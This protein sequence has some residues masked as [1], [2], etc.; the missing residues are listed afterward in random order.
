MHEGIS[1]Y[2][3]VLVIYN[4]HELLTRKY[5]VFQLR[6]NKI[7]LSLNRELELKALMQRMTTIGTDMLTIKKEQH[8]LSDDVDAV[9]TECGTLEQK[10][11]KQ[12]LDQ[13][14]LHEQYGHSLL[15]RH[16]TPVLKP[17]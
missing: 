10:I 6:D 12:D 15:F 3:T 13:N 4:K 7:D 2:N 1:K 11:E 14:L 8:S 17:L 9:K 16:K 5:I